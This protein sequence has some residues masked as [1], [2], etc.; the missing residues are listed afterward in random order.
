[1]DVKNNTSAP[2]LIPATVGKG[3]RPHFIRVDPKAT[4]TDVQFDPEHPVVA[5]WEKSHAIDIS[6]ERP[7]T[8]AQRDA[9]A[10]EAADNAKPQKGPKTGAEGGAGAGS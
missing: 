4:R 7:Q 2:L 3:Q 9:A 1:M 10:K 8:K 6:G 5:A